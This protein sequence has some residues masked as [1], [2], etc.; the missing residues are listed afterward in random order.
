MDLSTDLNIYFP[1]AHTTGT[2]SDWGPVL[3]TIITA[4]PATGGTIWLRPTTYPVNTQVNVSKPVRFMGHGMGDQYGV[5]NGTRL[6]TTTQNMVMF[7]LTSGGVSFEQLCIEN[8]ASGTP[9]AGAGVRDNGGANQPI[10]GNNS[11][12]KSGTYLR[13]VAIIGFYDNYHTVNSY[14]FGIDACHFRGQVRS[15]VNVNNGLLPDGGDSWISHTLFFPRNVPGDTSV[16]I[17]QASS[18]G[19]RVTSCKFNSLGKAYRGNLAGTSILKFDNTSIE[20]F[21]Q[22][23]IEVYGDGNQMVAVNNCQF[24]PYNDAP[25]SH[26]NINGCQGVNVTNNLFKGLSGENTVVISNCNWVTYKPNTY[27]YSYGTPVITNCTNVN[28]DV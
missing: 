28:L 8:T 5:S 27:L 14:L 22:I 19:L 2:P 24:A 9:T 10:F 23:G 1:E 20:N 7:N 16:G 13:K 26:I 12:F 17:L 3:N 4:M 11:E 6:V 15:A 25:A 21:K 18:G